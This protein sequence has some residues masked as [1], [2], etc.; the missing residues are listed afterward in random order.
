MEA[1]RRGV[2]IMRRAVAQAAMAPVARALRTWAAGTIER[3][4]NR[5]RSRSALQM[6]SDRSRALLSPLA[7]AFGTWRR[8]AHTRRRQ[9]RWRNRLGGSREHRGILAAWGQWVEVRR[10]QGRLRKFFRRAR[11][12]SVARAFASWCAVR[13]GVLRLRRFAARLYHTVSSRALSKW[14]D[15]AGEGV[16]ILRANSSMTTPNAS[17]PAVSTIAM[18]SIGTSNNAGEKL[19]KRLGR[20][21]YLT[22]KRGQ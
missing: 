4:G 7:V 14:V 1:R 3:W 12:A 5:S 9:T 22:K 2:E 11:N 18:A 21:C 6:R 8:L 15:V 16:L 13:E 10:A 17:L 20:K 19:P